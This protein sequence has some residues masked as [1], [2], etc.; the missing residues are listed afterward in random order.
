MSSTNTSKKTTN[1]ALFLLGVPAVLLIFSAFFLKSEPEVIALNVNTYTGN[2]PAP[3]AEYLAGLELNNESERDSMYL[4]TEYFAFT[5]DKGHQRE[6]IILQPYPEKHL[7]TQDFKVTI[8]PEAQSLDKTVYNLVNDAQIVLRNDIE[9]AVFRQ[10]L[11]FVNIEKIDVEESFR[12][13]KLK[14]WKTVV[15]PTLSKVQDISVLNIEEGPAQTLILANMLVP[16]LNKT[17]ED[18]AILHLKY[19]YRLKNDTL[20]QSVQSVKSFEDSNRAEVLTVR[21]KKAFWNAVQTKKNTILNTL[22]NGDNASEELKRLVSSYTEGEIGFSDL[23][24]TSKLSQ[25]FA[26]SNLFTGD[27][28]KGP[29]HFVLDKNTNSLEPVFTDYS[30]VGLTSSYVKKPVVNDPNYTTAFL[31]A[32]KSIAEYNPEEQLSANESELLNEV[33]A[34]NSYYPKQMFSTDYLEINKLKILKNLSQSVKVKTELI[35]ITKDRMVLNV[36]NTSYYPINVFGLNHKGKK[37]II[38]LNP[39][40]QIGSGQRDTISIDLPRSFENLFV[41]KKSKSTG[42]LLHKHIYDLYLEYGTIDDDEIYKGAIIPYLE[43]EKVSTDL[44]REQTVVNAH[45]DLVVNEQTK[46]ISFNKPIVTISSPLVISSE[47]TFQLSAGTRMDI[48][49]GGKIISH[50]PLRFLGTKNQPIEIVSSDKRGQGFLIL[51]AKDRSLIRHVVF[52]D[53]RNP[54]HGT[55][56]V[57]GAVTFYESPVDLN[58]VTISGN[59]CED[60]LNIVRTNFVMNN[61]RIEATQSDAFDGDFVQGTIMNCEFENLG[62]DAID[63][64]GSNLIIKNTNVFAAKDKGLSAGEDSQMTITNVEVYDSE[65][66][67]AGKDLSIVNINGLKIGNTKLAFTAF[68]KKP[69]FGP[70]SIVAKALEMENVEID[71]LIEDSSSMIVDGKKIETS[72]NV[73]DRMYGVEFGRSSAETRNVQNQR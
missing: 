46:T 15:T 26:I 11:P 63:V 1:S 68:Q 22:V 16:L 29:L 61:S 7:V 10:A 64:S 18:R 71:Y 38:G 19:D 12:N 70:S 35:S 33:K 14:T 51:S 30:C 27:C 3:Y 67:V 23:F 45:P 25:Y 44:F 66:A 31:T 36:L 32:H 37:T 57:T 72:E 59:A 55:W 40:V 8:Y 9:F 48:I 41:S 4:K 49:E 42:F 43:K 53:L 34:I 13:K 60:A 24:N 28:A 54:T 52:R 17:L 56:N 39:R 69:E 20:F 62:N 58:F 21:N 73:K 5:L 6:L 47:Y 50:A 65:I 2:M